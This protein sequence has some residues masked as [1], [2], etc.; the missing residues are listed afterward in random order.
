LGISVVSP[1]K[2]DLV[3]F[4]RGGNWSILEGPGKS[5]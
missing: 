1:D 4:G 2:V 5:I 3:E